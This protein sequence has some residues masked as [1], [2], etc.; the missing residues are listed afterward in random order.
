[1]R[2]RVRSEKLSRSRAQKK[3]LIKSLLR[4]ILINEK[5][6]TTESKAKELKRWVDKYITL[7]KEDTLHA[8]RLAYRLLQDHLLV[9]RLFET[10][11]PRFKD[12]NG[13]FTRIFDLKQ[14]RGDGGKLSVI[15]LTKMEK[16]E[17]IHKAKEKKEKVVSE[18]TKTNKMVPKKE[19]PKKGVM[20]GIKK[21]FKKE[22]DAL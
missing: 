19:T 14:R 15:E 12:I 21:I 9:K 8:R 3:A 1:M 7:A 6:V 22:R 5:I 17:K 16:K 4:A 2:H 18:E 10:I 11:A 13:G 20:S